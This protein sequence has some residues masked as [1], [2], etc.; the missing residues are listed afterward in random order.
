MSIL[1]ILK[2]ADFYGIWERW[3]SLYKYGKK[4]EKQKNENENKNK[5]EYKNSTANVWL[6]DYLKN[7]N[8]SGH[9]KKG[10][11]DEE[12]AKNCG[13]SIGRVKMEK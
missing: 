5:N 4:M 3:E 11:G 10:K 1:K 7:I 2:N 13:I 8:S 9:G 12:F 6:Y